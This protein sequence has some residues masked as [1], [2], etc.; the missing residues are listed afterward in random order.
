[1]PNKK[2]ALIAGNKRLPFQFAD[3]AKRNGRDLYI[4][5]MT[6]EVDQSLRNEVSVDRYVEFCVT[7]VSAIIKFCKKNDIG[8]IVMI[9]GI[10]NAKLKINLDVVKA[11]FKLLFM[12]NRHKGVFTVILSMFEKGGIRV[13]AI[14]EYMTELIIGEGALGKIE[15]KSEDINAFRKNWG[16]LLDYIRTGDGQAAIVYKG[17]ILAFENFKGTDDLAKRA[18]AK[19]SEMGAESGGIMV[20]IMEPGQD[21][22]ADLPVVG[23]GTIETLAKYS[24]DGVVVEA[25]R[26][27][28][29]DTAE[30]IA[31]ADEKGV[32]VYGVTLTL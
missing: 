21:G 27:I 17:E 26:T 8:E 3:W 4:I 6:G 1:M 9:G 23:T 12:K 15:P 13:R 32:F 10:A 7:E 30:T 22:R 5:G 16:A 25:G 14:Q 2:I 31:L 20:K 28:T 24:F 19:R 11:A 29:D 18:S